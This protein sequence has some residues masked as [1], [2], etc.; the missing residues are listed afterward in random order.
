MNKQELL[1][2]YTMEQLADMVIALNVTISDMKNTEKIIK[3][4][5]KNQHECGCSKVVVI[6]KCPDC[7]KSNKFE[8]DEK[9]EQLIRNKQT[10]RIHM[11]ESEIDKAKCEIAKYKNEIDGLI[12]ENSELH[13][14]I[15]AMNAF[16]EGM[17]TEPIKM[18]DILIN[19]EIEPKSVENG[20][21]LVCCKRNFYISELRQ[22]AQHLLVYC[23]VN[24]SEE[25]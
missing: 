1:E 9:S 12:A 16:H 17:P 13:C 2:N 6:I 22:I 24:E 18:A 4:S 11:L 10:N 20:V 23:N 21:E 15:Q 19:S 3:Q 8:L 14:E 5:N 7:G 25:T